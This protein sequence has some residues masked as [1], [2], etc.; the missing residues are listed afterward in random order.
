MTNPVLIVV[1][2]EPDMADFVKDVAE[3][4]GF[5]TLVANSAKEFQNLCAKAKPDAV[6]MDIVMPDM[7]GIE[8]LKW[9]SG[10]GYSCPV[11]LISGYDGGYIDA[12]A[13]LGKVQ[14]VPVVGTLTK[15][16]PLDQMKMMLTQVHETCL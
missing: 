5:E 13:Q 12:A 14:G 4:V 7:D 11:I 6:V 16:I 1:D 8:L 10:N 15:P 9:I 3:M 2:D